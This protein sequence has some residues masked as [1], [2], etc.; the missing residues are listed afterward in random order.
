MVPN[1]TGLKTD[2]DRIREHIQELTRVPRPCHSAE[3]ESCRRY[4]AGLLEESGWAVRRHEWSEVNDYGELNF[5]EA[6]AGV[7]LI[8]TRPASDAAVGKGKSLPKL[9]VGAHLDSRPD[10][11]GADDNASAVAVLLEIARLLC[12]DWPAD[13]QLEVEL[14]AFDLEENGMLG[15]REHARLTR[16]TGIDLLGMIS[17]EMLGYCD[18]RSNSQQLPRSL[19][20]SYPDTGNFIAIIGNQN[21]TNLIDVARQGMSTVAGLPVETLQ[22]PENGTLLQATRLSD[23]SPFWDAGFPA[24]MVTDTSFLR[25]PHYHQATDTLETLDLDFLHAVAEGCL[26]AVRHLLVSGLPELS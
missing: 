9:C 17:L 6:L 11:P 14:V 16:E 21:S 8:A 1:Q 15:G 13:A 12:E 25:N 18:H 20:G 26:R 19:V 7:N 5:G 10:T 2:I 3:L 23:H 22:V 24:L 4:V